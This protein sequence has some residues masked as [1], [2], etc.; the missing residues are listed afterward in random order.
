[1]HFYKPKSVFIAIPNTILFLLF[2]SQTSGQI[3]INGIVADSATKQ[4]LAF[5][6]IHFPN[7]KTGIISDINGKFYLTIANTEDSFSFS[8]TG[9]NNRT[10]LT[11]QLKNQDTIFLSRKNKQ[12][13]NVIITSN[14]LI[15]KI[16]NNT[17]A[18][19]PFHNPDNYNKYECN[20]Y[21][22]MTIDVNFK[23][24]SVKK[25]SNKKNLKNVDTIPEVIPDFFTKKS[26]LMLAET[27]TKRIYKKPQQIEEIMLASRISGLKNTY[28]TNLIT[29]VL[30]FHIYNDYIK[31]NNQDYSNPISKGWQNRY[32]FILEDIIYSATDTIY[33]LSFEPK[34]N[35][36]FNSLRGTVF[37][38]KSGYAISHIRGSTSDTTKDRIISFEQLYNRIENRW[39][40]KE[41][42]YTFTIKLSDLSTIIANGHSQ[43]DSASF[44]KQF[45]HKIDKAHPILISDSVDNISSEKWATLRGDTLTG[46]ELNTYVVVDSFSKKIHLEKIIQTTSILSVNKVALGKVDLD[47]NSIIN[48]NDYEGLRLGLGLYTNNKISK[49]YSVGGWIAYGFKDKMLKE[50][51][52]FTFYPDGKKDNWLRFST[53]SDVRKAGTIFLFN[54][55][56]KSGEV[57]H[58]LSQPD[59]VKEIMLSAQI[60][61][62]YTQINPQVIETYIQP[63]PS[64]LFIKNGKLYQDFQS[65]EVNAGLRFAY[66]EKRIPVLDYYIPF[67]TRYPIFYMRFGYGKIN[68]D[69]YEATYIKLLAAVTYSHHINRW[70]LDAINLEAGAVKENKHNQLPASF[71]FSTNGIRTNSFN[72]Y[73]SDGFLTM[74]PDAYF[75]DNFFYVFYRHDFDKFLWQSKFSKPFITL[76]HN[77]AIG[78]LHKNS[79]QSNLFIN[80]LGK[81]YHESGLIINQLIKYN[82]HFSDV[83]FNIGAFHHWNGSSDFTTNSTIVFGISTFF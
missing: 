53:K 3:K 76:A 17:I 59:L 51:G 31:L 36:L 20:I 69:D 12:L 11:S 68:K 65:R 22:K 21:Y 27:Y 28:F 39:F 15:K 23:N 47:I 73:Y 66:G 46:R 77:I 18:N 56:I 16:I 79:F 80:S 78:S 32:N 63:S 67:F 58:V 38:T 71:L 30:P 45:S 49:Y 54:D 26:Y 43:I 6:S 81:P 61:S 48:S 82:L 42:N 55:L 35:V 24:D 4:H 10:V 41:L 34:K 75:S 72:H 74:T 8:Y 44:D 64:K 2:V 14:G 25:I 1:M 50:G 40:P 29:D 5:A 57:S 70:G 33:A 9:Y 62:G 19:K 13:K 7:S 83:S 52:S 37:I 60:Q